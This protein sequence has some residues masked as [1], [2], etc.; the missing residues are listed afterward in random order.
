MASIHPDYEYD[1]FISYR[2][3]DNKYDGW[4]TEFVDNLQNE[5]DATLKNPVSIYFDK[6]PHDG[7]QETHVVDESLK[8]KLKCLIFIPI[9]SQTYCDE[10]SFAWQHEFLAFNTMASSD[11]LGMNITLV[12]G[13]VASRILPIR[14]HDIDADDQ[15]L[16]ERTIGSPM[17]AID[18]IYKEAGVNRSIKPEDDKKDNINKTSYRNQMNKVAHALKDL[19]TGIMGQSEEPNMNAKTEQP[20]L[21]EAGSKSSNRRVS[22]GLATILLVVFA[23]FGYQKYFTAPVE[24]VA[25]SLNIVKTIAV[26][27]FANTKPD[28][29]TD[30]LGF[31]VAN[32]IIGDLDYNKSV[33]VRP[34][35][36]IRQY[37][38][39]VIDVINVADDLKVNY[40][41]TGT[42]LMQADI[43]RL[44]IELLDASSNKMIWRD[45]I[46]VDYHNAFELQD[47][48]A[49]KVV[50]SLHIKFTPVEQSRIG[51]D[52][53]NDPLAYE[54][55]L[56]GISYPSTNEGSKLAIEM[57][58]QSIKLDSNFA[59]AYTALGIRYND[60][61]YIKFDSAIYTKVEEL[62]LKAISINDKLMPALVNLSIFYTKS[63]QI[64]KALEIT[65]QILGINPN[66]AQALISL[67]YIYRYAGMNAEAVLAMAKAFAID[68]RFR[69]LSQS[70]YYVGDLEKALQVLD[71]VD[72]N[73]HTIG[74]RGFYLLKQGKEEEAIKNFN[75]V[76][77]NDPGGFWGLFADTEKAIIEGDT[78]KALKFIKIR[79]AANI[80]DGEPLYFLA[81]D[82]AVIGDKDGCNRVLQRSIDA[83]FFNYPVMA[84]E[85]NLDYLRDDPEFQHI[86]DQAR[87]QHEAFKEKYF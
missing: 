53:P 18:F 9:L 83:G 56:R 75:Q 51:K 13:N 74:M 52:I 21:P 82:Y 49:K 40:V 10:K 47:I 27:P 14:I 25:V 16:F 44:N 69:S 57:L 26:L 32:Q 31:A 76:I 71:K 78:L 66:F 58:N 54:Y 19:G 48:V 11:E 6:N 29:N 63:A 39:K 36:A 12:N 22:L 42:Y 61:L 50:S 55:Y 84:R 59:T 72:Q 46:E 68:P 38:Q 28:P 7:L 3:N 35:S 87:V 79:E 8:K 73:L 33:V 2:Q 20:P 41:L 80:I 81:M 70:Y 67:G 85:L 62:Y 86:L 64:E 43:I 15:Q 77:D 5:L 4:V 45:K 24:D 23:Y 17:R 60:L 1:I 30:F 37:D 65:R 34:A